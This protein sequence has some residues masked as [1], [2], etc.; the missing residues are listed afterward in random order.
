[1]KNFIS[2]LKMRKIL[3]IE[4]AAEGM[5]HF[6]WILSKALVLLFYAVQCA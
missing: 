5:F 3:H 1:M 2:M 4:V 6:I